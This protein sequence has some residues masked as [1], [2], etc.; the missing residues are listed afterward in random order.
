MRTQIKAVNAG[1]RGELRK[2]TALADTLQTQLR[3]LQT[4][5][6]PADNLQAQVREL[7]VSF[8]SCGFLAVCE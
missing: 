4:S 6:R 8:L 1:L 5:G 3:E 2:F 7:Q